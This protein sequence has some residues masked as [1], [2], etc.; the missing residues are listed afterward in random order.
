MMTPEE[1]HRT[2]ERLIAEVIGL[3]EQVERLARQVQT[4]LIA[5]RAERDEL[6][7]RLSVVAPDV[8]G[9]DLPLDYSPE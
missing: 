6:R 4:R 7:A 9:R 1:K 3:A 2:E 5:V 8:P